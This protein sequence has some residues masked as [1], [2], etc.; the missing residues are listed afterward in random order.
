MFTGASVIVWQHRAS[1]SHL[2][3][4]RA[5]EGRYVV[6]QGMW[7]ECNYCDVTQEGIQLSLYPRRSPGKILAQVVFKNKCLPVGALLQIQRDNWGS[8]LFLLKKVVL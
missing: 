3:V 6:H 4:V 7:P 1:A 8:A 2:Q 5:A